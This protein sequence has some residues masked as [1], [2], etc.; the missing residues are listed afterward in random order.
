MQN[1]ASRHPS[2]TAMA[3]FLLLTGGMPAAAD[4][5]SELK[6]AVSALQ[7]RIEQ[8]EAQA[9]SA[10]ET[11]DRQTDQIAVARASTGSWVSNFTFKGDLRYRNET[12]D[13]QYGRERN[14]DRI[15]AR[16]GFVAKVNDSVRTEFGLATSDAGD[17][18]SSNQTLSGGNSR[19]DIY[20]DLAY[21]EW[22]AN[23]ALKFTAGKMKYPWTRAGAS[24]LFDSDVNP[25][26]MAAN[27]A[28]GDVFA[29]AFYN[30]LE[31]R[32]GGGESTLTGGQ[33]GWKPALGPGRATLALAYFDFHSVQRRNPF[34]GG[35]ANGNTTTTSGCMGGATTCLANDYDL[36]EA[37]AEYSVPVAA[38]PFMVYADYVTNEAASNGMD[39]AWSLGFNYGRA[40][41]PRTWEFG[42]SY[43][44][45]E[46]DALFAQFVDSDIG[47]GNTDH[48][49]HVFRVGYALARNWVFNLTYQ[50]AD[51]NL[52]VPVSIGGVGPVSERDYE[53]LQVDLNF[54]Y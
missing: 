18:R 24:A 22:Q 25:E 34:H 12:I 47:A 16:A 46:K 9:K 49:A 14:R 6:A 32:S 27:W 37:F 29:S 45:V 4:E 13:Q 1:P 41:D 35:S 2:I 15:R 51:T 20:L 33:A 54:R 43:Q 10:E 30:I 36:I 17:P 21:V 52:D 38:R 3:G 39:T 26:G 19:K 8:L 40:A 23:A 44:L 31:E 7:A 28:Q 5:I 42:Y 48:R 11:N 50:R 53:R